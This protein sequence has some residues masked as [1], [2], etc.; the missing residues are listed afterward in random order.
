MADQAEP[1][2]VGA[3]VHGAGRQRPQRLGCRRGSASII[4]A[5][6]ASTSASRRAAE[7]E[8]GRDDAGAERL[9]Q[10]QHVA[11]AGAGVGP[12]ARRVDLA[13]DRVAELDLLVLD[14]VAAEQRDA[15][16]AQLSRPP[17]EDLREDRAVERPSETPAIAS[18]VSG[19]PPIA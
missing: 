16:L 18:A 3:G 10:E 15:G 5:I 12:D 9:G 6:A 19:R 8:R 1:G 11:G 4:D 14:R 7:L 17:G 13:G 2:D